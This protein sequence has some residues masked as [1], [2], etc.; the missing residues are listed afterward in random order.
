EPPRS[1]DISR[2]S[3]SAPVERGWRPVAVPEVTRKIL[4]WVGWAVPRLRWCLD[5]SGG[6]AGRSLGRLYLFLSVSSRRARCWRR[7]EARSQE[8]PWNLSQARCE[9]RSCQ[10]TAVRWYRTGPVSRSYCWTDRTRWNS[11]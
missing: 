2:N 9:E 3:R 1:R 6:P 4:R 7:Q 10:G 5:S 11:G 8:E